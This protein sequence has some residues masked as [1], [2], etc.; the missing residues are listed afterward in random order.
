MDDP[1]RF[2]HHLIT[3]LFSRKIH[4]YVNISAKNLLISIFLCTFAAKYKQ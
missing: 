4:F 1:S 2:Y 3:K